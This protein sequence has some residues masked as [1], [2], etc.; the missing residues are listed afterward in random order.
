[1]RKEKKVHPRPIRLSR[2]F[3]AIAIHPSIFISFYHSIFS[4]IF[5]ATRPVHMYLLVVYVC[6]AVIFHLYV[7]CVIL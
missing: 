6:L 2:I 7:Q 1:V 4:F 3:T 5:V